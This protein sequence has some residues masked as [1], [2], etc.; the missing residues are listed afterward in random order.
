M[1]SKTDSRVSLYRLILSSA[2]EIR[3]ECASSLPSIV[4]QPTEDELLLTTLL[5]D[6]A[7]INTLSN[8]PELATTNRDQWTLIRME[9]G[10]YNTYSKLKEKIQDSQFISDTLKEQMVS[11]IDEI[12]TKIKV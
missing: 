5:P 11:V 7:K 8:L 1:N 4:R 10:E 12:L 6:S 2:C 3:I 9:S